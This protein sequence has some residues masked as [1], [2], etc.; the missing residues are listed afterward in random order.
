MFNNPHELIATMPD[1]KTCRDY[2]IKERWNG[3]ITCLCQQLYNDR[4]YPKYNTSLRQ[5][6]SHRF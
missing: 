5:A 3:I 6:F 2:L 1:E 4:I